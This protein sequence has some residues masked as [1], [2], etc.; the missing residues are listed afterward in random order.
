[1]SY[2]YKPKRFMFIRRLFSPIGKLFQGDRKYVTLLSFLIILVY[3][4]IM[5]CFGIFGTKFQSLI[6]SI[7]FPSLKYGTI[8]FGYFM[9]VFIPIRVYT[10]S[11]AREKAKERYLADI[12]LKQAQAK[13][14]KLKQKIIEQYY[15][16]ETL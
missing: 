9:A 2:E 8:I 5:A 6:L 7:G 13:E 1:M 4:L 12:R 11:I 3:S 10:A 15:Q 16:E 14:K